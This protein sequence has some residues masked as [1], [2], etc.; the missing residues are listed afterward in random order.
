MI[1]VD[2]HRRFTRVY[3]KAFKVTAAVLALLVVAIVVTHAQP[4]LAQASSLSMLGADVSS[5]QRAEDLGQK[6]FYANGSQ[7]DP[8]QILKSNGVNYIRLRIWN[9]PKSGYNNETKVLQY[10]KTVKADGFKLL[11]DFHYSDTWA[12]PGHQTE[13]AAWAGHSISQLQ[14]DV[15]NYTNGVCNALKAQGTTPDSVQIGNE[16][17]DGMLWP[18]GQINNNNFTNVGLLLKSG[19]NAIKACNSGT[20]VIIH[21]ANGGMDSQ[22]RWFFDGIK[23]QGVNWDITGLSYYSMWSGTMSGMTSTV[24]DMRSR[25]GKPVVIAE[26]AYPFTLDNADFE[27]NSINSSSQLTSGY[28]ATWT[29]QYNNFRDV[30]AAA[31]A[32]GAI[33]VFYWEPTWVATP[34]NGWDPTNIS[35]SGDGWDNMAL[36]NWTGNANPALA[37]FKP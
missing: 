9:N 34:G 20:Q 29:G 23:A 27:T 14:T 17:N 15:Y 18:T 4:Q 16:I 21:I 6:Y 35:G 19:Y 32:G 7:G 31:R 33:G 30:L 13:P 36:F 5:L 1:V 28:P 8:L 24:S 37:L 25:Y 10:A 26:T 22:A 2:Y 3:A 11:I 12:D